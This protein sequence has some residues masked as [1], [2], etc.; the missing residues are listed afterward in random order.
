MRRGG[1][2][3]RRTAVAA[4]ASGGATTAPSATAGAH[5]IAGISARATTAT[6]TVVRPTAT[7][8]SPVTGTQLSLRS[9]GDVSYAASSS[10]GATNKA[11]ASSGGTVND[12]APGRKAR[13]TPATARNTGYGTPTRRAAA[14]SSTAAST[15]PTTP[16]SSVI[17]AGREYG[18]NTGARRPGAIRRAGNIRGSR[19]V[20]A[21]I[22]RPH[23][24]RGEP[25]IVSDFSALLV[26]AVGPLERDR[27]DQRQLRGTSGRIVSRITGN[28]SRKPTQDQREP[29]APASVPGQPP[30]NVSL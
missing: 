9:L 13:S 18:H 6:A 28:R 21:A 11:S 15:S 8:A 23:E 5:G 19:P 7:T 4:A 29:A 10:T 1:R 17:S 24:A 26:G 27:V 3:W 12:G 25:V 2:S 16:S 22:G 30:P 20:N 14:A